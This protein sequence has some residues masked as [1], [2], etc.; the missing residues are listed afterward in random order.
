VVWPSAACD[1]ARYL[2]VL[3]ATACAPSVEA[4]DGTDAHGTGSDAT[5][6]A[7]SCQAA[8]ACPTFTPEVGDIGI[9][10]VNVF[11][12][13]G[14]AELALRGD[15]VL[16]LGGVWNPNIEELPVVTLVSP[17]GELMALLHSDTWELG[18]IAGDRDDGFVVSSRSTLGLGEPWLRRYEG[19]GTQSWAAQPEGLWSLFDAIVVTPDGWTWA[20]GAGWP[21]D[22]TTGEDTPMYV[23]RFDPDGALQTDVEYGVQGDTQTWAAGI[24]WGADEVV[25]VLGTAANGADELALIDEHGLLEVVSIDLGVDGPPQLVALV[26]A[27]DRL[28]VAG[29]VQDEGLVA[30]VT[31]DGDPIWVRTMDLD[32]EESSIRFGDIALLSD[33]DLVV[34]GVRKLGPQGETSGWIVRM[35]SGG[36]LVG[37]VFVEAIEGA[38][39][40]RAVVLP[41]GDV[42]LHGTTECGDE[43][44]T[45]Q[46]LARV[47]I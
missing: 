39:V 26:R 23:A 46:W 45:G 10:W 13:A 27:D 30:A 3:L 17:E 14:F 22:I 25:H 33:G 42:V 15:H 18:M 44:Q 28:H 29:S 24:T 6:D 19:A 16:T 40:E 5:T 1:V 35:T 34:V 7:A 31:L 41:D 37:S 21:S 32:G 20:A 36:E 11:E 47:R 12:Y 8:P 38:R 9:C 4:S 43:S 2:L